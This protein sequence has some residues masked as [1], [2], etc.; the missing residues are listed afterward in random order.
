MLSQKGVNA[1][2]KA[3]MICLFISG[4][5]VTGITIV[6]AKLPTKVPGENFQRVEKL[7]DC[8]Q[9]W[10]P[11]LKDAHLEIKKTTCFYN[12]TLHKDGVDI[13]AVMWVETDGLGSN[14]TKTGYMNSFK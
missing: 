14:V 11:A 9:L 13:P 3:V 10:I 5:I 6:D 8:Q 7:I 1:T 4:L 12:I 2:F